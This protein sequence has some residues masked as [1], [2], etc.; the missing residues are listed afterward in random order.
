MNTTD[1]D[2]TTQRIRTASLQIF[3]E[4]GYG[5]T[6]ID[7]IASAA[8]VGVGTIYRRWSDKAA[9]A[10][11]LYGSGVESMRSILDEHGHDDPRSEFIAIWRRLWEWAS[12]HRHL[13]LFI[14]TSVGAPWLTDV[15]VAR[16]AELGERELATYAR[17]RI[18]AS[19]EF[20]QTLVGATI[21]AVLSSQPDIESD[22]VAERLW[23][24]LHLAAHE[25]AHPS[26]HDH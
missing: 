7:Q 13:F 17:L 6:T 25:H 21:G 16:K 19:P 10:N 11:D 14:T 9:I 20:A 8:D 3:V 5:N 1:A 12:T 15:N 23:R 22:E 26:T 4:R 2:A 18:D 24:A